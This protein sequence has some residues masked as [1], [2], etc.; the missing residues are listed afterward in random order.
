MI[1]TP[2]YV[3]VGVFIASIKYHDQKQLEEVRIY[4]AYTSISYSFCHR[5]KLGQEVKQGRNLNTETMQRP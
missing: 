3:L 2:I 1:L 5:R 4:F